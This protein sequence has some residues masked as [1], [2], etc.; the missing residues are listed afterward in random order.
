MT[1]PYKEIKIV[2]RKHSCFLC[3]F[4]SHF[5]HFQI[6]L[7]LP[8]PPVLVIHSDNQALLLL[9]LI[10]QLIS[11]SLGLCPAPC[12]INKP[13]K[14]QEDPISSLSATVRT[15]LQTCVSENPGWKHG[16]VTYQGHMCSA[17]L[18]RRSSGALH[19]QNK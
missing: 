12:L 10:H 7:L 14:A 8:L 9:L 11:L 18:C 1:L 15:Q 4:T 13:H 2:L 16:Y 3:S 6:C 17:V 19:L 5:K